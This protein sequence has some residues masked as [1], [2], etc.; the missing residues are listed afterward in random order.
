MSDRVAVTPETVTRIATEFLG[1]TLSP[2]DTNAVATLLSGLAVDM[3][4]SRKM[5]A[6]NED[7]VTVYSAVEGQP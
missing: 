7:P 3:Q 2:A 4:A 1:V 6:A 5:P